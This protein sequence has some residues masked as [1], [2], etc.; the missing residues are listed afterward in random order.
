M[1][2]LIL[3]LKTTD[4][5]L[6]KELHKLEGDNFKMS[7]YTRDEKLAVYSDMTTFILTIS[8]SVIASLILKIFEKYITKKPTND[9]TVNGSNITQNFSQITITFNNFIQTIKND[10]TKK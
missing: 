4:K 10:K 2:P 3:S 6:L 7:I 8:G 1:Q 5:D 9:T